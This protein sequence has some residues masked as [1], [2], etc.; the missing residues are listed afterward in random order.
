M[1]FMIIEK[2][3]EGKVKTLYQRFDERGRMLPEGVNY[4]NSWINESVTVCYQ[5]MESD[6]AENINKWIQNWNDL[7]DF[8]VVSVISSSE[9]KAKVMA[10]S[11]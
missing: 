3:H 1:L 2:F 6:S 5:L 11:L 10:N 4:I 7:A 8:E 9:A